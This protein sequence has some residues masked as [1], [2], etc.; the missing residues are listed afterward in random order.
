[1]HVLRSCLGALTFSLLAVGCRS[2]LPSDSTLCW[3]LGGNSQNLI[4]GF[5]EDRLCFQ[6]VQRPTITAT[7]HCPT[8]DAA[9]QNLS[10]DENPRNL[11]CMYYEGVGGVGNLLN[12]SF[13]NRVTLDPS[14]AKFRQYVRNVSGTYETHQGEMN[15]RD[16]DVEVLSYTPGGKL[17]LRVYSSFRQIMYGTLNIHG[18]IRVCSYRPSPEVAGSDPESGELAIEYVFSISKTSPI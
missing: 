9:A 8:W 2:E 16:A 3:N 17:R 6:E 15:F 4:A 18:E 13:D 11:G 1:M 14:L 5:C 10:T 12:I 7:L